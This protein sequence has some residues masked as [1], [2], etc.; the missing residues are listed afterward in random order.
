MGTDEAPAVVDPMWRL[1]RDY[2]R[3]HW[4]YAAV[5]AVGTLLSRLLGLVPAFLVGLAVDAIFLDQRTFALP[6]VPAGWLPTDPLSQLW[7]VVGLLVA[8]TALGSAFS[9]LQSWN[10]SVFAQTVQ[11]GLR[12]DAYE[13]LQRLDLAFFTRRRTG[14]LMAVLN[15]DVD[16]LQSFLDNGLSASLRVLAVVVGVGAILFALNPT[17]AVVTMVPV[18]VLGGFTLVFLRV[19]EPR[20][21]GIRERVGDLNAQLENNVSGIETVKTERAEAYEAERVREAAA[22]Y[23]RASLSAIR[24]RVTYYPG[25]NLISGIGFAVTIAVG[26]Y[27]VLVG[28]PLGLGDTLSPGEFVTFAIYAQ[29][30]VWPVIEFG[31]VVDAYGRARAAARRVEDLLTRE[32]GILDAKDA[33][34]LEVS[35]GR[36]EYDDVGFAYEAS[37]RTIRGVS[38]DV[39]G[40][41]TVGVVGPT[42]A[43]KST[44]LKLLP[45]LYDPDEGAVRIDGQDVRDVTL[46]SLR[47][48]V[49]YVSQEPFLFYGSVADNVRY[50]SFDATDEAVVAAAR[51]AQAHTFVENLPDGYG[52]MVGE[53]GVK[54]SGGQ[55]Q[56]IALARAVLKDPAILVLDEATSHV[57]TETEALIQR[58]LAPLLEGRT[59]FVIAHRLSTVRHADRI[60]VVDDGRVVEAGTHEQ[61]LAEDG[62]YANLWK[63]QVGDVEGLTPEFVERARQHLSEGAAEVADGDGA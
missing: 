29:Q 54:L 43:G 44:L 33:A 38:F 59:A 18:V 37:R 49:G 8:A 22:Q 50:G 20:Y 56:R 60:L 62:L 19:I 45:R 15:N 14:E 6:L 5:G 12:V 23:L 53:R 55:R 24:A 28:P 9:W 3:R 36:V 52:T 2:G 31:N 17:L 11:Y 7:L 57:D 42:G 21:F 61:L 48:A 63:V 1:Y 46:A 35:A 25:L 40:G 4:R 16:Q 34:P 26:G 32:P 30:F 41:Q 51:V 13:A 10:W 47:R 58:S 27:W 39:E